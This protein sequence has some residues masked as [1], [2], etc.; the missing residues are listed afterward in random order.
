LLGIS[1]GGSPPPVLSSADK[2]ALEAAGF[3]VQR[4]GRARGP[5]VVS[6]SGE[7]FRGR[8]ELKDLRAQ[9]RTGRVRGGGPPPPPPQPPSQVIL[10][11]LPGFPR[12]PSI[13]DKL[14]GRLPIPPWI[15]ENL[16]GFGSTLA[17]WLGLGTAG[18][19]LWPIEAGRGSDLRDFYG[20]PA[21]ADAPGA[22]PRR[23]RGA[24]KRRGGRPRRIPGRGDPF[25]GAGGKNPPKGLPGTGGAVAGRVR[26]RTVPG[27]VVVAGVNMP[28]A[29]RSLPPAVVVSPG[30]IT[31]R[32]PAP[33]RVSVAQRA[34]IAVRSPAVQQ[35]LG[36]MALGALQ[37][38][39][40]PRMP[41]FGRVTVPSPSLS[42][43]PFPL[44][45]SI[46]QSVTSSRAWA[47]P[48][49]AVNEQD[50]TCR[51]KRK[52]SG[53]K[54]CKNPVKSRRS[55]TRDGKRFVTTT[56]ELTCPASS[57]KKPQSPQAR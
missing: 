48:Q 35:A 8:Q 33:V 12:G 52:K 24:R 18:A 32:A 43:Y 15:W 45:A 55:F 47:A 7:V 10:P 22:R 57:R 30:E 3:D 21:P 27:P 1:G 51:P 36:A 42:P 26:P 44:T 39:G 13:A 2:R 40:Q 28:P 56:K 29:P 9:I 6:P 37:A 41:Q 46:P 25:P 14:P 38:L 31:V 50:C 19:L 16:P 5:V 20:I 49:S 53:K 34:A 54:P 17:R 11:S 23:G 4:R